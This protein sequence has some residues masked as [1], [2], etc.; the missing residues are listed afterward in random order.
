MVKRL[1]CFVIVGLLFSTTSFGGDENELRYIYGVGSKTC[2]QY[3]ASRSS[4]DEFLIYRSWIAGYITGF[5]TVFTKHNVFLKD[6]KINN[7][8]KSL[9]RICATEPER[10]LDDALSEILTPIVS[11]A[12]TK[13]QQSN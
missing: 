13:N 10:T 3:T 12:V 9:D 2:S 4:Q 7:M 5:G 6:L 8:Y 1:C 11:A